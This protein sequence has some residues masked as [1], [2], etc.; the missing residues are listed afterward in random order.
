[1]RTFTTLAL[2]VVVAGCLMVPSVVLAAAPCTV[3]ITA[4]V[5][6]FAEWSDAAPSI[7]AADWD[8][9][10]TAVNQ[11]RTASLALTLYANVATTVTP[12][13]GTNSGGLTTGTETLATSYMITGDVVTPD[14]TYKVAADGVGEFF[15]ATNTYSVT[16]V[17]GDGSYALTLGVQAVSPAARA[18]DSGDY[19][20]GVVL[21]ATW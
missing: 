18:P 9:H 2:A 11:T 7:V 20:C 17:P 3:T 14:G 12:T 8:G 1:M 10:I 13:A 15:E 16:H 5:D 19:S 21:T 4:T 6:G